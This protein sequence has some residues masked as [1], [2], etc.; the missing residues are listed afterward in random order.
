M[1]GT[2]GIGGGKGRRVCVLSVL[3]A[4][5]LLAVCSCVF[6]LDPA[7]D[8]SQHAHM[9]TH[10]SGPSGK[11]PPGSYQLTC[12]VLNALGN[13]LKA[14][15]QAIN[16]DW[17]TTELHNTDR[18]AADISNENGKLTCN[19]NQTGPPDAYLKAF[20]EGV[21]GLGQRGSP[22]TPLQVANWQLRHDTWTFKD[23]APEGVR[24][25]AQA[26]D[27]VLWLGGS[28]GLFRFDGRQF[29]LFPFQVRNSVRPMHLFDPQLTIMITRTVF[30]RMP[31]FS[32]S[33]G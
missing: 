12:V 25:L 4:G 21:P 5:T 33:S 9:A 7:L 16:G 26:N 28:S 27:G 29:E 2:V 6:A 3:L 22:W 10:G 23:G 1:C 13:D 19:R 14:I 30:K 8:V 24:A 15:C 31:T 18:C 11:A 17:L 20:G 32:D